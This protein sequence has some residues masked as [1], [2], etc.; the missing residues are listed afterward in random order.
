MKMVGLV[1]VC[2]PMLSQ[3]LNPSFQLDLHG[4]A[5]SINGHLTGVQN[6]FPIDVDLKNDLGLTKDG[7]KPGVDLEYQGPRFDLR[8][9]FDQENFRGSHRID[10]VITVNGYR[11]SV[12][13]N[14]TSTL[15][16]QNSEVACTIRFFEPRP[17]WIG[18]DI[19]IGSR[20][21]EL[22]ATGSGTSANEDF[23]VPIP[24]IGLSGGTRA[25]DDR[26]L[27]RGHFHLMAYHG[28]KYQQAAVDVRYFPLK[29]L[30]VR[31]FVEGESLDV[32]KGSIKQDLEMRMDDRSAG[33]GIVVRF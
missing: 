29:W 16:L 10:K 20:S 1:F 11:F 9:S 22:F 5:P 14:V 32:P 15:K 12:G 7:M 30:G 27:I 23:S 28:M 25:L 21:L 3:S 2:I 19:G 13:T 8:L 6:G 33:L 31:A 18:A 17:Y 24:Q 26:L 4:V